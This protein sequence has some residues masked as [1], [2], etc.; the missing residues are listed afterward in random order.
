[1]KKS[2]RLDRILHLLREEGGVEVVELAAKLDVSKMTIRR[3]LDD[4]ERQARVR[5]THGGAVPALIRGFEAPFGVRQSHAAIAKQRIGAAAVELLQTGEI[6]L[7]DTGTTTYE[8]ARALIPRQD[9]T[10]ITPSLHIA[11]LLGDA[12]GIQC[13]A[14]GGPVRPGE[15]STAGSLAQLGLQSFNADVCVLAVGGISVAGGVTEFD[16]EAAA[17]TRTQIERARRAIVVAD[18]SKLGATTFAAVAGISAID[19][20]VTSA[21]PDN[22]HLVELHN[23]GVHVTNVP[24][25]D[26]GA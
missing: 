22:P 13:I 11:T 4:L 18:E 12:S 26:D 2:E 14:L 9:L 20:L 15:N 8:V 21:R 10:V 3:D 17:L 16:P 1:M 6:V 24:L 25:A 23:A 19:F 5:R 7:L